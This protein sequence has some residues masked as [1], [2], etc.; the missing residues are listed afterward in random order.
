MWILSFALALLT[1]A[2]PNHSRSQPLP[3]AELLQRYHRGEAVGEALLPH[4]QPNTFEDFLRDLKREGRRLPPQVTA[5]FALEASSVVFDKAPRD[6]RADLPNAL[7]VLELG[8]ETLREASRTA[9]AFELRWHVLAADL[10]IGSTR[11]T[12]G[13]AETVFRN[14]RLPYDRHFE[15]VRARDSSDDRLALSV[16]RYEHSQFYVWRL[17]HGFTVVDPAGVVPRGWYE[18][19]ERLRLVITKLEPL[20]DHPD[21]AD[22]ARV[23][24]GD[25]LLYLGR[26]KE[27]L[28]FLADGPFKDSKWDYIRHLVR[29]R[30]FLKGVDTVAAAQEYEAARRIDPVSRSANLTLAGLAYLAGQHDAARQLTKVASDS[31]H[32]DHWMAYLYPAAADWS[33]R[34]AALRRDARGQ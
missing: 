20:L 22:E 18:V 21:F 25:A 14:Y 12:S 33:V 6:R 31:V 30:A 7:A 4:L 9:S 3:V 15:H 16:A 32:P 28:G 19:T 23:R 10:I 29:A 34:L 24:S 13:S 5:S 8:C 17:T 26:E 2:A 27:G 1:T 11:R